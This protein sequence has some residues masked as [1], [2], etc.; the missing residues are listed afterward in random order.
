MRYLLLTIAILF[1]SCDDSNFRDSFSYFE[2]S[3]YNYEFRI[4][5]Y[6][7]NESVGSDRKN[8]IGIIYLFENGLYYELNLW[9]EEWTKNDGDCY[10][11]PE[12]SYDGEL[13]W[14]AF[15]VQDSSLIAIQQASPKNRDVNSS[16]YLILEG[17][18]LI[19]KETYDH[20]G[21]G[22]MTPQEIQEEA[23]SD[24]YEFFPCTDKP[25]SSRSHIYRHFNG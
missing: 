8:S 1:I 22:D 9:R 7:F 12:Y 16:P 6:F 5:G 4:D 17:K 11:L 15:Q 20:F 13:G 10:V 25:D 14:G 19:S 2:D 3:N 24:I 18:Y 21:F 23:P